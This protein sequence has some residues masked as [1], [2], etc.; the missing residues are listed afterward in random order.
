[1]TGN[2]PQCDITLQDTLR[3]AVDGMFIIDRNFEVVFFSDGCERITGAT[4]STILGTACTC[5]KLT[6]CRDEHGRSLA[7]AL[8]PAARALRGEIPLYRQRMDIRQRGGRR[9]WVETTYSPVK[10][11][12]G[13][14]GGVVGIMR[15]ITETKRREDDL[16]KTIERNAAVASRTTPPWNGAKDASLSPN[17]EP[18]EE[19]GSAGPLDR[20]L[21]AIEKQEILTALNQANGQRTL[22]ARALGISRSRLYRRMEA[23]GI[24]PRKVSLD[25]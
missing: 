4:R 14:I 23:L 24:D 7:G 16:L 20:M 15:D 13:A 17:A 12:R 8:C 22:A 1:M 11:A 25:A 5:H 6:D 18:A 3:D 21:S 2:G 9:V 19:D 10:G